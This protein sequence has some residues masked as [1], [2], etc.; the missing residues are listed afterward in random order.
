VVAEGWRRKPHGGCIREIGLEATSLQGLP[1]SAPLPRDECSGL[2][3]GHKAA[4]S[5]HTLPGLNRGRTPPLAY[6]PGADVRGYAVP[7]VRLVRHRSACGAPYSR[8]G[9]RTP[10]RATRVHRRVACDPSRGRR[11]ARRA[12][13]GDASSCSRGSIERSARAPS[14]DLRDDPE[15]PRA[16]GVRDALPGSAEPIGLHPRSRSC[17][18]TQPRARAR[19]SSHRRDAHLDIKPVLGREFAPGA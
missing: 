14:C 16:R 19:Y 7:D 8:T 12:H 13:V 2:N 10:N 15:R 9:G 5:T 1:P 17:D 11:R 6:A 3:S 4:W 18:R